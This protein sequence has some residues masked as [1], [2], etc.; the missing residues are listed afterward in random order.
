[1]TVFK[2]GKSMI[3]PIAENVAV[4]ILLGKYLA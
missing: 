3:T 1:M 4:M 2:T